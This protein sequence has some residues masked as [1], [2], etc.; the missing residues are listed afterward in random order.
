M[1][2]SAEISVS[3]TSRKLKIMTQKSWLVKVCKHGSTCMLCLIENTVTIYCVGL[4]MY[5]Y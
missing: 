4:Y 1:A 3:E 5:T 2:P